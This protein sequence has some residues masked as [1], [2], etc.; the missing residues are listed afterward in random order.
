MKQWVTEN[1]IVVLKAD[2]TNDSPEVDR[3]LM[4]LGNASKA[5]PYY[6]LLKPGVT[7]LKSNVHFD[8]VFY[9]PKSFLKKIETLSAAKSKAAVS[10][11]PA[12]A[13][14]SPKPDP[15]TAPADS[16]PPEPAGPPAPQTPEEKEPEEEEGM[17]FGAL[18]DS[19]DQIGELEEG[20]MP[21]PQ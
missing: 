11:Q 20:G 18:D 5:I 8:G 2:K 7:P 9:T 21:V 4:Q 17:A 16:S 6:A 12:A 13:A 3:L 19:D 1:K 14:E 15:S 10:S